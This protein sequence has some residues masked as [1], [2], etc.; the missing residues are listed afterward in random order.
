MPVILGRE[1][2]MSSVVGLDFDRNELS[3]TPSKGFAAP[4]GATEVKLRRDGTLHYVPVSIDGL[5]PVE[6][7]FDLGNGG[8][9]SISKEYHEKQPY[10]ATLPYAVSMSGGVGG[11]HEM[12]RV[13][14]P[15]IQMAGFDFASVPADLGSLAD[16][17][18][19]NGANVGIQMF[20]PFK[21]TLDLG[22]DRMWLQRNG[23]PAEFSK[24][25]AGMFTLLEGDHF[26]V[27]HVSPGSAADKAGLKKGDRLV[28]IDGE[29]VGPGFFNGKHSNWARSAAGT[30]VSVT[31]GD[32]VTVT[33]TLADYF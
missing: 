19:E 1:L 22:H 8:A 28:A 27:L 20:M 16:G 21:L 17:P 12:K 4:S 33:M 2:F 23:K 30:K 5:P 15:K 18:Y 31:R 29:R 25:R 13:S 26:N 10:F 3:L 11:V 6:A 24:D 32:G 7:A 9:L 14:L